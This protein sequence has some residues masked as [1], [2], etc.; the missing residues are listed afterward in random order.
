MSKYGW[1]AAAVVLGILNLWSILYD[2]ELSEW[3]LFAWLFNLNFFVYA[4]CNKGR[5]LI[6]RTDPSHSIR[7]LS[8]FHYSIN[9]LKFIAIIIFVVCALTDTLHLYVS[10]YIIVLLA[11]DTGLIIV[12]REQ[13]YA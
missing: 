2:N 11:V 12:N 4:V 10:W 5:L 6:E 9:F 7:F 1:L 8:D 13:Q 3:L